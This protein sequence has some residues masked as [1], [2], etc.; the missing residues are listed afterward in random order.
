LTRFAIREVEF[1]IKERGTW[2]LSGIVFYF[3][4]PLEP[5]KPDVQ[6]LRFAAE[7]A[8]APVFLKYEI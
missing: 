7:T 5:A 8:P 4:A 6:S 3:Q 2:W 1:L